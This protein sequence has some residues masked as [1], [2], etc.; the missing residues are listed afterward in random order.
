MVVKPSVDTNQLDKFYNFDNKKCAHLALNSKLFLLSQQPA[1]LKLL[2]D[3]TLFKPKDIKGL[4][5][6]YLTQMP[7]ST[8]TNWQ[9]G[10]HSVSRVATR[11]GAGNVNLANAINLLLGG[12]SVVYYGDEIGME[13]SGMKL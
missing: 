10:D 8:W 5:D 6:G 3:N 7:K 12:T 1:T 13:V 9:L 4:V 2:D 11:I